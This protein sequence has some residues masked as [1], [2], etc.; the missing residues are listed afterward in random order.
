MGVRMFP[1][2]NPP[3]TSFPIPSLWQFYRHIHTWAH[4]CTHTHKGLI[5]ARG[6]LCWSNKG[7]SSH[8][9]TKAD[10]II[11]ANPLFPLEGIWDILIINPAFIHSLNEGTNLQ[12]RQNSDQLH[13]IPWREAPTDKLFT[14]RGKDFLSILDKFLLLLIPF[15]NIHDG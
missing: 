10:D 8:L 1:I 6:N 5:E 4:E 11:I 7:P 2:L 15:S 9:V 13:G 12:E 14:P 3:P